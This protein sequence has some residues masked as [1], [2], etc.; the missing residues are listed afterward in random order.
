MHYICY[1]HITHSIT[2]MV[3]KIY[4]KAIQEHHLWILHYKTTSA[5]NSFASGHEKGHT[6]NNT[7]KNNQCDE[8]SNQ[9][10]IETSPCLQDH[11]YYLQSKIERMWVQYQLH[12][13]VH[14]FRSSSVF[15]KIQRLM[16]YQNRKKYLLIKTF[17][18]AQYVFV[19]I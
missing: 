14:I 13:Y 3:R 19:R 17:H 6:Q 10:C 12:I 15:K 18:N 1:T 2:K 7:N 4:T 8:A 9:I 5:R 11:P 16:Y